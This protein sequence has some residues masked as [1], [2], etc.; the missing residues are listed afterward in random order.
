MRILVV[1]DSRTM[2]M[3]VIR[4]LRQAGYGDYDIVEAGDGLEAL[5][6]IQ[7]GGVDVVLCDWNMPR[8]SGLEL[9]QALRGA[10]DLRLFGFITSESTPHMRGLAEHEGAAFVI[11]KPFTAETFQSVLGGMDVAQHAS[12]MHEGLPQLRHLD[13]LLEALLGRAVETSQSKDPVGP[14]EAAVTWTYTFPDGSIAAVGAMDL[15]LAAALGTGFGMLPTARMTDAIEA[16]RLPVELLDNLRE[17]LNVLVS[18]YASMTDVRIG[19]GEVYGTTPDE[20]AV[21]K[22]LG[23]QGARLDANIRVPGYGGGGLS[24]VYAIRVS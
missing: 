18:L 8:M 4:T 1:D 10:G 19:L 22:V 9:L 21:L 16:G 23:Q 14:T 24:S 11:S 6:L 12:F 13:A 20:P 2:R 7:A 17:V 5:E 15:R 3:L